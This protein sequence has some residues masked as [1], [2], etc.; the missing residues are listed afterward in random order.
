MLM[1]GA[2]LGVTG[3]LLANQIMSKLLVD[4]VSILLRMK[5]L[6]PALI[7]GTVMVIINF[8]VNKPLL[9]HFST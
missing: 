4:N 1:A 7:A 6:L 2:T 9:L 5:G 3:Y 8:Q